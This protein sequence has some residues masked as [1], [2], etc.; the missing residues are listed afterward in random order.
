MCWDHIYQVHV[1]SMVKTQ[2]RTDERGVTRGKQ[3]NGGCRDTRWKRLHIHALS[4]QTVKRERESERDC[5]LIHRVLTV[6]SW[7]IWSSVYSVVL[8]IFYTFSIVLLT[9]IVNSLHQKVDWPSLCFTQH[10]HFYLLI[11][12]GLL[13]KLLTSSVLR[14][15]LNYKVWSYNKLLIWVNFLFKVWLLDLVN[16]NQ[17]CVSRKSQ[18]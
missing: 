12:E 6:S 15:G 10:Q 17:L 8:L 4:C 14:T 18:N 5:G 9:H 2:G 11:Y 16:W 3:G 7:H 13:Q 1:F